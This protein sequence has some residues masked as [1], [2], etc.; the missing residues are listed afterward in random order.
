MAELKKQVKHNHAAR[1]TTSG[2]VFNFQNV[3][4]DPKERSGSC[5]GETKQRGFDLERAAMEE[6][7]Q[8]MRLEGSDEESGVELTLSIGVSSSSKKT[9]NYRELDS[10]ASFKSDSG[11][12]TPMSSSSA[13]FDHQEKKMPHWLLGLS[14]NRS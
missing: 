4:D 10:S 11:P 8:M 9:S 14:I 3:S 1:E 2:Y 7:N 13:T 12:N 5:S 6:D